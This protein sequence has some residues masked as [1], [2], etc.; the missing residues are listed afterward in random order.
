MEKTTEIYAVFHGRI[1]LS[2]IVY[3]V[4]SEKQ[5]REIALD[6]HCSGYELYRKEDDVA[7]LY[8]KIVFGKVYTL[9]QIKRMNATLAISV[10]IRRLGH[11]KAVK[12]IFGEWQLYEEGVEYISLPQ[13]VAEVSYTA[14][15]G[16]CKM[17]TATTI[18]VFLLFLDFLGL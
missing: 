15:I 16:E 18:A 8:R 13:W 3:K 5:A 4:E 14:P 11:S 9:N 1:F 6:K 2:P 7:V 17:K 12:T 10:A